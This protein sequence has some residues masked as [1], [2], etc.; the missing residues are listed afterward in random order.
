MKR[1]TKKWMRICVIGVGEKNVNVF[2]YHQIV[3]FL[4]LVIKLL[5]ALLKMFS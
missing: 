5:L 1:Y 3:A 2:L 4:I